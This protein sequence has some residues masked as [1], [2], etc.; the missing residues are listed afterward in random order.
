MKWLK[1]LSVFIRSKKWNASLRKT[2]IMPLILD[3]CFL[4]T[5]DIV[6]EEIPKKPE[7]NCDLYQVKNVSR[8]SLFISFE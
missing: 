6:M 4:I 2:N 1:S 3:D 7:I 8:V 5:K